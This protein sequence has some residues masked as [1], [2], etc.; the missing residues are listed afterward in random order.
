MPDNR[1]V[2][3]EYGTFP[4]PAVAMGKTGK[5]EILTVDAAVSVLTEPTNFA[6]ADASDQA[7]TLADGDEAQRKFLYMSAKGSTG[8]AVVTPANLTGGT[9][10]TFDTVGDYAE[11][12]FM[13]GSWV[14]TAVTATVA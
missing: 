6:I 7:F 12:R 9:T 14:A 1:Y 8:N 3:P 5:P 2:G 4:Y 13:G 11:L 10:I